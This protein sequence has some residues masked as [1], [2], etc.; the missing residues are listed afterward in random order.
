MQAF[1][2]NVCQVLWSPQSSLLPLLL[3]ERVLPYLPDSDKK[4]MKLVANK[5]VFITQK[6]TSRRDQKEINDLLDECDPARMISLIWSVKVALRGIPNSLLDSFVNQVEQFFSGSGNSS[7]V[8]LIGHALKGNIDT[9]KQ[10]IFGRPF[11]FDSLLG[12]ANQAVSFY[13]SQIKAARL[14][15]DTWTL[16]ATRLHVINDMR[17]YIGKMIWEARFEAN[18]EFDLDDDASSSSYSS[19][20]SALSSPASSPVPKRSRK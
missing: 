5:E 9:E 6:K 3:S 14:A 17:I 12:P 8:F 2:E 20:R 19:S 1:E 16:V 7:I 10:L 15:V 18:Y 13:D 4:N 11:V